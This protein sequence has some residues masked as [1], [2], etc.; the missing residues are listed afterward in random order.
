[1]SNHFFYEDLLIKFIYIKK[2]VRER[3]SPFL[4]ISLFDRDENRKIV[5]HIQ[6]FLEKYESFPKAHESL[7]QLDMESRDHLKDTIMELDSDK[8]DDEFLF[9]NLES[10][11]KK[12]MI[13]NVC[14][15][16]MVI[17]D[18]E[19][20]EKINKAPDLLREAVAF[21]FKNDVGL[22]LFESSDRMFN[23]FHEKKHIIP[24]NIEQLNRQIDGGC[25]AK[26]L[27]LFMAETN[28][29]K[30]LI[31]SS[32]GVGNIFANK[33]VLYISCELSENSTA[34]RM[35]AN[36]FDVPIKD[37]KM[38]GEDTFKMKFDN[39][40]KNFPNKMVIKE[41]PAKGINANNI[42]NLLKE[43]EMK[44]KFVP[45]IIYLDQI[46]NMNS[47]HRT[48]SDNTYTEMGRVTQE[49]RGVATDF[50]VPIISAIQT[51]RDGFGA[52]EI[53]L[54]NTGDSLGFVQTAD[55]VIAITQSEEM[56]V[57]G[58]FIWSILKNRYGINK[59]KITVN[60]N[61]EKMRVV[62]D[63]DALLEFQAGGKMPPTQD[64]LKKKAS[65]AIS[66]VT[67]IVADDIESKEK[68]VIDWE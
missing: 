13:S 10:F 23:Y 14:C 22:D 67:N 42:R 46:G 9:D 35:L 4:D 64:E 45:D 65:D 2:D 39:L 37:L 19:D 58:K 25:H 27:I 28:M 31:M 12:K 43:L 57:A 51:N 5:V 18:N 8:Y 34:E 6:K 1:V 61:Y 3:I 62:D 40:K 55:V 32:L 68:N 21:S 48:K 59:T 60:V 66:M 26:S 50:N 33:N 17:I 41:Y 29:G 36:L 49:V 44:K 52:A 47:V 56:R 54:T 53:D 63:K 20:E 7:L 16:T 24:T 15:D 30:S 38:I 11:I